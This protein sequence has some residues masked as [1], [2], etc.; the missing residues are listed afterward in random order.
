MA[1]EKLNDNTYQCHSLVNAIDDF[2]GKKDELMGA[3]WNEFR[4]AFLEYSSTLSNISNLSAELEAKISQAM[5]AIESC[6]GSYNGVIPI[7]SYIINIDASINDIEEQIS[8]C[9]REVADLESR[10]NFVINIPNVFAS[11]DDEKKYYS[12]I[13][14]RQRIK[15]QLAEKQEELNNL[16]KYHTLITELRSI[17]AQF[18]AE[19]AE[20]TARING[21]TKNL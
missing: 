7:P 11:P 6:L 17:K 8:A 12:M 14:Y 19:F 18:E 9:E 10:S 20:L 1:N 4:D 16:K 13:F 21:V 15:K 3:G 2:C 5:S